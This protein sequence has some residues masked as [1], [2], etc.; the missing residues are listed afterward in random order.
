MA[1]PREALPKIL[2]F[3][4]C[5]GCC[6]VDSVTGEL[7]GTAGGDGLDLELAAARTTEAVRSQRATLQ[8]LGGTERIEDMLVTLGRQYHLIR[9]LGSND[10]VFLYVVLDKARANLAMT[11]HQ[12]AA[13]ERELVV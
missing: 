10:A 5:L 4:G 11:R 1:D 8:A 6:L 12:L 2:A 7:L 9:T 13:I 3:D